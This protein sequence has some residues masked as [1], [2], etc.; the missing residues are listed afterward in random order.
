MILQ[1]GKTYGVLLAFAFLLGLPMFMLLMFM[2]PMFMVPMFALPCMLAFA[3]FVLAVPVLVL[4]G[5]A[6]MF[7]LPAVFELLAVEQPAQR[8]VAVS[9][10]PRVIVRRIEVPSVLHKIMET[11]VQSES[12]GPSGPELIKDRN[13]IVER[14]A[15]HAG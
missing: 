4:A 14:F 12:S 15:C 2:L 9:K 3:L 5:V 13:Y 1:K 10:S 8:T 6:A 7:A 11:N